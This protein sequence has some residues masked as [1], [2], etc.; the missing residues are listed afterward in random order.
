MVGSI[1]P[2]DF[3]PANLLRQKDDLA[4]A[5]ILRLGA[6]DFVLEK[7]EGGMHL[8]GKIVIAQALEI[9]PSLKK[10]RG[11]GRLIVSCG[12]QIRCAPESFV[13]P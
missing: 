7:G 1:Q 12:Q 10:R 9:L 4:V 6:G 11:I 8:C 2:H 5:E 13:G 3:K